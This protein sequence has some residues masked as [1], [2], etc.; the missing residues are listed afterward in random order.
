MRVYSSPQVRSLSACVLKGVLYIPNDAIADLEA[1][2]H[3]GSDFVDLASHVT[4]KDCRPLLDKD[5]RALH[6]GVQRVDGNGGVS[7]DEFVRPGGRH[8][9]LTHLE[10]SV[11]LVQPRGLVGCHLVCDVVMYGSLGMGVCRGRSTSGRRSAMFIYLNSPIQLAENV[12]SASAFTFAVH[13]VAVTM[14]HYRAG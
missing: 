3:I 14:H 8:G 2:M 13:H 10:S 12:N 6:V 1:A 11:G 9:S 5:A 7:D 4:A